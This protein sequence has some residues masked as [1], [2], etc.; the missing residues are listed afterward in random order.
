MPDKVFIRHGR[1]QSG[2][3]KYSTSAAAICAAGSRASAAWRALSAMAC[4]LSTKSVTAGCT[5]SIDVSV[6]A[7]FAAVGIF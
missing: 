3:L 4:N 5:A 1:V 7:G 2:V 6:V